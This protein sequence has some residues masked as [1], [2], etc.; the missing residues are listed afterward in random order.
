MHS[1]VIIYTWCHALFWNDYFRI[2]QKKPT[3]D[4]HCQTTDPTIMYI[5]IWHLTPPSPGG[6]RH[7]GN[8][9][10]HR[11]MTM[12]VPPFWQPHKAADAHPM[13]REKHRTWKLKPGLK[14]KIN[15]S[16]PNPSGTHGSDRWLSSPKM[17]LLCVFALASHSS[18]LMMVIT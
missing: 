16:L 8:C 18:P 17:N 2:L 10:S 14:W 6:Q 12:Q 5:L 7:L 1:Q 4:Y 9:L 13:I 11:S 15:L 3:H